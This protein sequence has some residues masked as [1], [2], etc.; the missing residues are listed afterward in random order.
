MATKAKA[1]DYFVAV[2]GFTAVI[3][4]KREFFYAGRTVVEAGHPALKIRPSAFRPQRALGGSVEQATAAP[5]ES[6]G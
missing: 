6:R 4:G 2:E 1:S 5:G 3:D